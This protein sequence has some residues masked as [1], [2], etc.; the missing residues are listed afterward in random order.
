MK[1]EY[2]RNIEET[3]KISSEVCI[4]ISEEYITIYELHQKKKISLVFET[5]YI[6]NGP[7]LVLYS[8]RPVFDSKIRNM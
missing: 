2:K 5:I 8:E 3:M 4:I 6:K 1:E 7:Q